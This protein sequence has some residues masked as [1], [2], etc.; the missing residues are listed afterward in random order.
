MEAGL[1]KP[2]AAP[3]IPAK[4]ASVQTSAAPAISRAAVAP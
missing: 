2:V 3:V 1:K 4:R